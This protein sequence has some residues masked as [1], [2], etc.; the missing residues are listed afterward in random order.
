M[1]PLAGIA[2]HDSWW[3]LLTWCTDIKYLMDGKA[4][5]EYIASFRSSLSAGLSILFSFVLNFSSIRAN[6]ALG[7]LSSAT[8][9]PRNLRE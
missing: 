3:G 9:D 6:F 8:I 2:S 7:V 1:A 5:I 4:Y